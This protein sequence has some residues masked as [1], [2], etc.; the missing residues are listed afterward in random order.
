MKIL[1]MNDLLIC[2]G[3]EIMSIMQ[4]QILEDKE[5]N[6][7][8]MTFDEKYPINST[9]YNSNN[10]FIN[11]S[12]KNNTLRKFYRKLEYDYI[13]INK[14]RRVIDNIKP[15]I[16]IVNNFYL[17][18]FSQYKAIDGYRCIQVIHD[19]S[20][21]CPKGTCVYRNSEICNGEKYNDCISKCNL[22]IKER[23]K[24]YQHKKINKLRKR[25]ISNYIS[26]S[27][28]LMNYC[29]KHEFNI[30]CVNNPIHL[31]ELSILKKDIDFNN[32]VYL[33]FG[34]INE[35]KGIFRLLEAFNEFSK[36]KDVKLLLIGKVE[37]IYLDKLNEYIYN[38]NKVEYIGY[39]KHDEVLKVLN[40]VYC[41][42]VPSLW[43]ENYPTTVLE[44]MITECLIL[45]SN[46]GGIPELIGD[47]RGFLFDI[48]NKENVKH[49]LENSYYLSK[50]KYAEVIN[51][52]KNYIQVNNN[53][54]KY[55][56]RL[57]NEIYKIIANS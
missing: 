11:I 2:G 18:P 44:A 15:D 52:A 19:Y 48:L 39:L 32:K 40:K 9:L 4:K 25:I 49:V 57:M 46:R 17:A 41:V 20:W 33:Y 23:I 24:L 35:N 7:Y 12:L 36:N 56:E 1:I 53:N 55:Y 42:L 28:M 54:D 8:L 37:E 27:K 51:N 10:G 34:A 38:N 16:I 26:P 5:H 31:T 30:S 50:E 21:V 3:A 45:G 29:R 6:V 13:L 22:S 47:D 14:I 43:M